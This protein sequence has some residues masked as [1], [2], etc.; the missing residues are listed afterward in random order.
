MDVILATRNPSKAEQI[1]AVFAGTPI[2]ILTLDQAGIEGQAEEDG[3]TLEHNSLV[4]AQY[5]WDRKHQWVIADDT[6]VFINVLGGI[7]GVHAATWAGNVS[8]EEA[9][10]F[11]LTQMKDVPVGKRTAT[12]RTLATVISPD[13]TVYTFTGEAPGTL[14][15]APRGNV[16]SNMPYSPLFVADGQ[17]KTWSEMS[18]D[19]ENAVSHRGKAFRKVR[20]FLEKQIA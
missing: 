2:K 10:Q 1:Q 16:Q 19:E 6:G 12:F 15:E 3:D 4:K 11:I 13:G 5:V 7:P 20:E 8:T 18:V 17:S 9:V 14:L